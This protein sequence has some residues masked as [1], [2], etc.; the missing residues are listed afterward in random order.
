MQGNSKDIVENQ[1]RL[2]STNISKILEDMQM[3]VVAVLALAKG[4][5]WKQ[6]PWQVLEGVYYDTG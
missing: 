2:H 4:Q 1:T 5:L 3:T 6:N